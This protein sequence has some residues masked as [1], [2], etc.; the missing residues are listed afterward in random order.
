MNM[1]ELV[2]RFILLPGRGSGTTYQQDKEDKEHIGEEV[3]GAEHPVGPLYCVVVKVTEDNPE[4]C[5]PKDNNASVNHNVN[6]NLM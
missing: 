4:L 2:L 1:R 6:N 5:E 3:D